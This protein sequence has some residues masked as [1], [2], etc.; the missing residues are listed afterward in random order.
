MVKVLTQRGGSGPRIN[1]LL[2]RRDRE[3]L[4][5]RRESRDGTH[6]PYLEFLDQNR[7]AIGHQELAQVLAPLGPPRGH[8][9]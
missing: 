5:P 4:R 7:A 9:A 2:A 6:D 8:A 1:N 3:P